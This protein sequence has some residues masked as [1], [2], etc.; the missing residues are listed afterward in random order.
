MPSRISL[1]DAIRALRAELVDA[2]RTHEGDSL[3]F[4]LGTVEV[5]LQVVAAVEGSSEGGV[6]F[7]LASGAAQRDRV[8][9]TSHTVRLSLMPVAVGRSAGLDRDV[10]VVSELE[11]L[12]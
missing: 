3:R 9:D 4:A 12:G 10:L 2:V 1:G 7:W 8:A 5:E 6:T 11:E